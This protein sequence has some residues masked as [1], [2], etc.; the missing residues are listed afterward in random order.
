MGAAETEQRKSDVAKTHRPGEC[1][2]SV[3]VNDA[4]QT[5]GVRGAR[6]GVN[7]GGREKARIRVGFH[8]RFERVRRRTTCAPS[9]SSLSFAA[10]ARLHS[11]T[12]ISRQTLLRLE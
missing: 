12:A 5:R 9:P 10:A 3:S 8:L 7:R 4:F 11:K 1:S 6:K 2:W